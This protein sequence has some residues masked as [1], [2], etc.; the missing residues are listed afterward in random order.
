MRRRAAGENVEDECR[1]V[2]DLDVEGTLEVA[3]LGGAEI[4]IDHDDVVA[5]IVTP[6][7]D[8]LEFPFANVGAG[9]WMRELLGDRADNLD[10]DGLGQPR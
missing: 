10:I 3:L 1:A 2:D 7:L 5:D 8:L 4:V 6:G 9:Q